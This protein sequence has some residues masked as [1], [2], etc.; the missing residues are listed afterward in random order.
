MK[1]VVIDKFGGMDQL[2]M[3]DLPTPVPQPWEVLI[4]IKYTSVNPVD[5]KIREGMFKD[6]MPH[7]FPLIL[8]WDA[9]GGVGSF[10]VQLAEVKGARQV[11]ATALKRHHPYLLSIGADVVIDYGEEDVAKAVQWHVAEGVDVLIDLVGEESLAN[12]FSLLRPG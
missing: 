6:A 5:W 1:A 11:F 3:V 7:R 9:A 2:K 10:A 8:G 12:S 4:E